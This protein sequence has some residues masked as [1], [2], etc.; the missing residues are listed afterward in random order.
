MDLAC[1]FACIRVVIADGHARIVLARPEKMNPLDWASIREIHDAVRRIEGIREVRSVSF[2]GEGRAFSAGGDLEKYRELFNSPLD[3]RAFMEEWYRLFEI[4]E[5]SD[6]VFIAAINGVCVAG[7]LE[8]LLACDLVIAADDALIGDGHLKYGQ[9]PGAGSSVR[10]WRAVGHVRAKHL[11]LTGELISA[12]EAER[13]GLVG[14]VVPAD[15]LVAEVD[16]L[17]MAI[18]AKTRIGLAGAKRLLNHAIR[19]DY[20]SALRFE[21]ELVHRYATTEAD[22]LEGLAA[23]N[24]KRAPRYAND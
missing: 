21:I 18:R 23:F 13:I 12:T 15:R 17:A 19:A 24:E 9:L 1:A 22:P 5:A 4:M 3:F 2:I 20:V 10:L 7:G 16:A 6:K 14:K 11:M 8:L